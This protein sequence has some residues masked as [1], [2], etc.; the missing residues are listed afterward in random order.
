MA[1]EFN[2]DAVLETE[3]Q[4]LG[5]LD[6]CALL[7]MGDARFPW[8]VMVPRLQGIREIYELSRGDRGLLV[9]EIAQVSEAL[10]GVTGCDKINVAALGN[11]VAQLHVH[12]IA[13][14]ENDVAWPNPIWGTG[15]AVAYKAPAAK[16]L[17]DD[18]ARALS[19]QPRLNVV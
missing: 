3:T 8:L 15:D 16:S 7:L 19:I 4:A 17:I 9:E 6:L 12:V 5:D 18:I 2:L 14:F 10:E 13:R 11:Q 1:N